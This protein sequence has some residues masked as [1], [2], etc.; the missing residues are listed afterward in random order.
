MSDPHVV[1]DLGHV[2][3]G[4]G[5]LG[6]RP[7]QHEFGLEY[8][9]RTLDDAVEGGGHPWNG[10]MLDAALDVGDAPAGVALVPEPVE[11]L[12]GGAKLYDQVAGEVRRLNLAPLLAPKA[13]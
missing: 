3:F 4:G 11:L 1:L 5:L 6:E 13:N 12:G 7:G 8:C 2:L 10:R 9:S